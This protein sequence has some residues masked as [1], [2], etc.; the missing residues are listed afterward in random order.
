M[1]RVPLAQAVSVQPSQTTSGSVESNSQEATTPIS[2]DIN[3]LDFPDYH[4]FADFF[5]ISAFDRKDTHVADKLSVLW[6][7]GRQETKS[8][9]RLKISMQIKDLAKRLGVPSTGKDLVTK[10]HQWIRLDYD[11]KRIESKMNLISVNQDAAQ[12]Y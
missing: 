10:L 7:W 4:R 11:R 6:E 3:F 9:D 12:T 1:D 8:D 5:D 2:R